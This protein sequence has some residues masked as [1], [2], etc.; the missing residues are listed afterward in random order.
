MTRVSRLLLLALAFSLGG[1]LWRLDDIA[2][3]RLGRGGRI[4]LR[5][6][7]SASSFSDAPVA[8]RSSP[9][10]STSWAAARFGIVHDEYKLTTAPRS[11]KTSSSA[12]NGYILFDCYR[13]QDAATSNGF[14]SNTWRCPR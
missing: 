12:V 11:A 3:R 7:R 4:L 2:G 1:R 10:F 9:Q 14:E 6:A 5:R 8:R 13:M